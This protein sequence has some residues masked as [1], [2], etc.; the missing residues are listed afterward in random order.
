VKVLFDTNIILDLL[1]DRQPFSAEAI[2]LVQN[3]EI[4]LIV[5]YLS[6]TTITTLQYL[7]CKV[8]GKEKAKVE[9]KKLLTLFEIAPV[10]RI[11]LEKAIQGEFHDFEDAVL[12]EAGHHQGIQAIVTRN[13]KDFVKAKISIYTP[14]QLLPLIATLPV[15]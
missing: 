11:V 5:G 4:G 10:N 1:L 14:K 2:Q 6:A 8:I 12:Y 3:V 15:G 13:I 7:A 9:I